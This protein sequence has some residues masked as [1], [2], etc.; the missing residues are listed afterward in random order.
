MPALNLLLVKSK[1]SYM[2]VNSG[3]SLA[4]IFVSAINQTLSEQ[5]NTLK[6]VLDKLRAEKP[7]IGP[8]VDVCENTVKSPITIFRERAYRELEKKFKYP[9]SR[10]QELVD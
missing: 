10:I 9:K 5:T 3:Q 2:C 7:A 1:I 4:E 8:E 6:K